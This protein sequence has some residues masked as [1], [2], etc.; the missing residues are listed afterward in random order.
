MA[1]LGGT[2]DANE[3]EPST[4]REVIP[5]NKYIAHIV[6]SDMVDTS[7]GTGRML[8]LEW[9]ILEGE[10]RERKVFS[11]LN[12]VNAS[13]QAAEIAQREL[14]AIC[15]AVGAMVV[16][17]SN[18]LHFKPALIDV[19][20][21]PSGVNPKNG[22]EYG[23]GNGIRKYEPAPRPGQRAAPAAATAAAS[24]AVRSA[25]AQEPAASETKPPPW[26]R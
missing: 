26:R 25:S 9:D 23:P 14:S 2:F 6:K 12:L 10:Y 7:G 4:P 21:T 20:V 19:T 24:H 3:V 13:A 15:R 22:K 8:V 16:S 1:Q 18:E 11:R 17:D 5:A